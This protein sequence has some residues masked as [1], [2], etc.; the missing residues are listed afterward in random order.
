MFYYAAIAWVKHDAAARV[1]QLDIVMPCVRFPLIESQVLCPSLS[2]LFMSGSF[3]WVRVIYIGQGHLSGSGSF[4]ILIGV[5]Y[6]GQGN[7]SGDR[8][9]YIGQDD[10]YRSGS[11]I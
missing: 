9:I 2:L 11:F 6:L 3:I 8:V 5:I 4:I 7:L 10:L 1:I